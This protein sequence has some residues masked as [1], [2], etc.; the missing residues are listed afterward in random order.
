MMVYFTICSELSGLIVFTKSIFMLIVD[1][2]RRLSTLHI[3]L[4]IT[5]DVRP[6]L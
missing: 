5:H 4:A 6:E 1:L 2:Y 3:L